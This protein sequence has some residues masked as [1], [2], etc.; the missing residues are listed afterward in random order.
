MI[1]QLMQ[2]L[3]VNLLE[4]SV[5]FLL[6]FMLIVFIIDEFRIK[7]LKFYSINTIFITFFTVLVHQLSSYE[8]NNYIRNIQ[9]L[10]IMN[11]IIISLIDRKFLIIPNKFIIFDLLVWVIFFLN[12]SNLNLKYDYIYRIIIG[13]V[14]LIF[15]FIYCL[16]SNKI[17]FG[18]IKMIFTSCLWINFNLIGIFLCII[19]ISILIHFFIK[20]LFWKITQK[21]HNKYSNYKKCSSNNNFNDLVK[22]KIPAAQH[23]TISR[24]ICMYFL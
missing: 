22:S 2:V 16:F 3:N 5:Y 24:I 19:G 14:M 15:G 7:S 10:T 8:V 20:F 18:D 4:N 12:K 11:L 1:N 17:G 23:I 21:K 6:T 13:V 9:Y